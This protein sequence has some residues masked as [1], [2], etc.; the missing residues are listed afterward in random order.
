MN[1]VREYPPNYSEIKEAFDLSGVKPLFPYGDTLYNPHKVKITDHLWVHERAHQR[2]QREVG[3]E[4]WW[5]KYIKDPEFRLA[6]EIEAY[7]KQYEFINNADIPRKR[8]DDFLN[9]LAL[10][11]SAKMYGNII[12]TGEAKS[13]IRRYAED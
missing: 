12:S 6:Q 11:V 10:A 1:E 2:Q 3:V 13:K 9:A 5:E 4:R 8:K 7:G